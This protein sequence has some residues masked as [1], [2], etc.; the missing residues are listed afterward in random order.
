M[1]P[2][3][4]MQISVHI[5]EYKAD[6]DNPL[7]IS[8]PVRFDGQQLSAFGTAYATKETY[9]TAHFIGDV[10]QG[11]SCN[12][13]VYS[14]SPHLNGTHTECVGHITRERISV[15]DVL[16]ESMIPATLITLSPD[17]DMIITRDILKQTLHKTTDFLGA[18]V[19]RTLPNG[20][21]KRIQDYNKTPAAYFSAEAMS[22]IVALGV[23]HLLV[24]FPSVDKMDDGGKLAN[25]RIFWGMP[26]GDSTAKTPSSKTITELIYIPDS[27]P[28]GYYL[29]NLQ[30]SAFAADAA[31]SR[32]LLYKVVK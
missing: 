3:Y 15:S 8:I 25:H 20:E 31:P 21:G 5:G 13:E 29:L 26:Q 16:K 4:L 18:L 7:D 22:D 24:D 2:V 19:I 6:I 12:C 23:R 11:G 32:P 17:S 1:A 14:F 10:R 9:K 28:D 27:I 30:V